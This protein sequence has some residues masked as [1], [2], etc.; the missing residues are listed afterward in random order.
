MDS[1]ILIKSSDIIFYFD[2]NASYPTYNASNHIKPRSVPSLVFALDKTWNDYF[3]IN[4][5]D[6]FFYKDFSSCENIGKVRII[7][8][9]QG[10][11]EYNIGDFLET[12]YKE[13]PNNF[14]SLGEDNN[15]Y[16]LLLDDTYRP[17]GIILRI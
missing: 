5:F 16:D 1:E 10:E 13:L 14:A 6:V 9:S 12:E 4:R 15:F 2:I 11:G 8:L 17:F 3:T 7:E